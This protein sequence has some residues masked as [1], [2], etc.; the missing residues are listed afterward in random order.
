MA[1]HPITIPG[2]D[3]LDAAADYIG[4]L[5]YDALTDF[6]GAL[7]IKLRRDSEADR[8]RGRP[9]LAGNI[10]DARIHLGHARIATE[11]AWKISARHMSVGGG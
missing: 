8:A 4:N 9:A 5:R 6:L 11:R 2:F 1:E 3:S 7:E 10:D